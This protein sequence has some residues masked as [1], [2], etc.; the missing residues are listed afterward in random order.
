MKK[1]LLLL[2]LNLLTILCFSQRISN[3]SYDTTSDTYWFEKSMDDIP[4]NYHF[5]LEYENYY[6]YFFDTNTTSVLNKAN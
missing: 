3:K 1:A 6:D 4:D 2:T 5:Y